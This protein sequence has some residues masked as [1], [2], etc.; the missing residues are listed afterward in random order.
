LRSV[1]VVE[2]LF[3]VEVIPAQDVLRVQVI[4]GRER[5]QFV[6]AWDNSPVFNLCQPADMQNE[7]RPTPACR[8]LI[9]RPFYLSIG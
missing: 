6:E 1:A 8:Q 4:D 5:I 7:F 2:A 9:A 3:E